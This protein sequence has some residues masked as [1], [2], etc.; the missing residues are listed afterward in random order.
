M[1]K[2]QWAV[3]VTLVIIAGLFFGGLWIGKSLDNWKVNRLMKHAPPDPIV[4]GYTGNGGLIPPKG[5]VIEIDTI[6]K[7]I[8]VIDSAWIEYRNKM[9]EN[10]K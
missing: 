4:L 5:S 2:S 7:K 3:V 8:I 1:K 10:K 9:I 6:N